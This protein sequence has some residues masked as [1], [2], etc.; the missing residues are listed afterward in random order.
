MLGEALIDLLETAVGAE[1]VYRPAVGGGPLNVAVGVTRLG[2]RAELLCAVGND[3]FGRRIRAFLQASGVGDAGVVEVPAQTTL[4]VTSFEGS[5]PDFH[6][7]G[8]PPSYGLFG[9]DDV[10][11]DLVAG[12]SVLYCGSIA[13]L[14][15]PARAAARKAWA[16]RGPVR[17]FD[18]NVRPSLLTGPEE[19][20]AVT[21]EFCATADLVKL[22]LDDA[23]VLYPECAGRPDLVAQRLSA[24]G[25]GTVVVTLGPDGALVRCAEDAIQVAGVPVRAVDTTGA[26]DACMAALIAGILV[27]GPPTDLWGWRSLVAGAMRVAAVVCET[28][29]GAAAMPDRDA[30]ASR[31]AAGRSEL[32]QEPLPVYDDPVDRALG[33]DCRPVHDN[34]GEA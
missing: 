21:A 19:I 29:G 20:R 30:V 4:A 10:A 14:C 13:L 33:C 18:P 32:L 16:T 15:Q 24:L 9:P 5:K 8:Q 3:A 27:A 28:P 6:F 1:V 34:D 17:V 11:E 12:A 2:G 26:G 22:S 25:A 23:D 7:Y 31:F